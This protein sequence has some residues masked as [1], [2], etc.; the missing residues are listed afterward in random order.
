MTHDLS[1]VRHLSD[2]I[3]VMY[4]GRIVE[5]GR[6]DQVLDHPLH[7]YTV[8]LGEAIPVPD[9]VRERARNVALRSEALESA[10]AVV[11][12]CPYAPRCPLVEPYCREVAPTLLDKVDGH[13]VSCHVAMREPIAEV[14]STPRSSPRRSSDESSD[15]IERP[16]SPEESAMPITITPISELSDEVN[17][18][19]RRTA[20][21]VNDDIL[22]NEAALWRSAHAA[23]SNDDER[24]LAREESRALK[25]S[26]KEKVRAAGLWAPHLPHEYGGAGLDFSRSPTCT[27]SSPTRSAPTHSLASPRPTRATPASCQIRH[28]GAKGEVAASPHR[29]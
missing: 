21:I 27:R 26:I 2:E 11:V 16:S 14:S 1:M 13:F 23:G 18:V 6:Y 15:I 24:D 20:T 12:G 29:G 3:A 10:P 4:F 25:E 22:P 28:R 19:R 5:M 9:P 17:D 7:P 8:A